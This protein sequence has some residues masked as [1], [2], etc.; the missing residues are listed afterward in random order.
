MDR[1]QPNVLCDRQA[2]SNRNAALVIFRFYLSVSSVQSSPVRFWI[3]VF[4]FSRV[5]HSLAYHSDR[6]FN[7]TDVC[8][9]LFTFTYHSVILLAF[10]CLFECLCYAARRPI[11]AHINYVKKR[12]EKKSIVKDTK[13]SLC[14]SISL[15]LWL[16]FVFFLLPLNKLH[17]I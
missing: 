17:T 8:V 12:S 7:S 2:S 4:F 13:G 3:E 11:A 5:Y 9:P 10:V 16:R 14:A 6:H 1:T 15:S